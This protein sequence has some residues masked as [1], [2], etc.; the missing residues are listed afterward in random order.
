M[1]FVICERAPSLDGGAWASITNAVDQIRLSTPD[2]Q[3]IHDQK[4]PLNLLTW[5]TLM[6]KIT[7]WVLVRVH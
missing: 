1:L 4:S 3:I 5:S 7:A 6:D 2:E